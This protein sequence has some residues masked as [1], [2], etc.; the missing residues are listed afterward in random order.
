MNEL[1]ILYIHPLKKSI[2]NG[3]LEFLQKYK[4]KFQKFV[5]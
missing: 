2:S 5:L 3:L 4:T 1:K